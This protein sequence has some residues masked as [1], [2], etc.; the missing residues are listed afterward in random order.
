M[1]N[2]SGSQRISNENSG[3][4]TAME[5]ST[6][7]SLMSH[8][9]GTVLEIEHVRVTMENRQRYNVLRHVPMHSEVL[10]VEIDLTDMVPPHILCKYSEELNKRARR[11]KERAKQEKREKRLE[12]DKS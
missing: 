12:H 10:L 2:H 7:P 1:K 5:G 8:V 11:R 9:T 6:A 3:V 4:A